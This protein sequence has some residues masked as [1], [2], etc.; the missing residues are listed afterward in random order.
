LMSYRRGVPGE[1]PTSRVSAQFSLISAV[2][3]RLAQISPTSQGVVSQALKGTKFCQQFSEFFVPPTLSC[4]IR[5]QVSRSTKQREPSTAKRIGRSVK[6][7]STPQ[8]SSRLSLDRFEFE[9]IY[10]RTRSQYKTASSNRLINPPSSR[11]QSSTASS[12]LRLSLPPH[13]TLFP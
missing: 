3:H 1:A 11:L 9:P 4:R 12:A 5:A 6:M 8:N 2:N 13:S 7:C 10:T